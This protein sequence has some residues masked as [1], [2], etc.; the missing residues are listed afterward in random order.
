[1]PDLPSVACRWGWV[2]TLLSD[3][4][5]TC[6]LLSG[7]CLLEGQ[8]GPCEI[9]IESFP[10]C[11]KNLETSLASPRCLEMTYQVRFG[12]TDFPAPRKIFLPTQKA[13]ATAHASPKA[14]APAAVFQ[15][16]PDACEGFRWTLTRTMMLGPG[17]AQR[18][19]VQGC[20]TAEGVYVLTLKM[21]SL[22]WPRREEGR[23]NS[24]VYSKLWLPGSLD[25]GP[26]Q[27]SKRPCGPLSPLIPTFQ[28]ERI[29]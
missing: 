5:H 10:T 3:P 27:P 7:L 23:L 19:W 25:R 11:L 9:I 17:A 2:F 22:N 16:Q 24:L 28:W 20:P 13:D 6:P 4:H 21:L 8:A 14:S 1:M 26:V 12:L 29:W 18:G 15:S